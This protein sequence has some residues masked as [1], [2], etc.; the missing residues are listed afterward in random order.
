MTMSSDN[1]SCLPE[2]DCDCSR[3]T[4]QLQNKHIHPQRSFKNN[5]TN[6]HQMQNNRSCQPGEK[7]PDAGTL[8]D[9]ISEYYIQVP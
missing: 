2:P 9:C 8:Q 3:A 6:L 5:T 7:A 4:T 1:S